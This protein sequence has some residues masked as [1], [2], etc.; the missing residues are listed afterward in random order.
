MTSKPN[1]E[2]LRFIRSQG[3]TYSYKTKEFKLKKEKRNKYKS[4]TTHR[5]LVELRQT[6]IKETKRKEVARE[7][8]KREF[9]AT[10]LRIM[11]TDI[12]HENL[13]KLF[14]RMKPNTKYY[15]RST[16]GDYEFNTNRKF[17]ENFR[18]VFG[19]NFTRND[20]DDSMLIN[21]M[22]KLNF[23]IETGTAWS[24]GVG[25]V[26]YSFQIGRAHV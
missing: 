21:R 19:H 6:K 12:D 26:E 10:I 17:V 3:Y 24:P 5:I 4:F 16:E 25:V 9:R 8:H 13:V 1:P 22:E 7:Y 11:G 20:S 14:K 2:F 18:D 23:V 15:L